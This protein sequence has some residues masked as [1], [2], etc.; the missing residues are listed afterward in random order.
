MKSLD[1]QRKG[2]PPTLHVLWMIP[3]AAALLALAASGPAPA[4]GLQQVPPSD[5]VRIEAVCA[6]GGRLSRVAVNPW[7]LVV[8]TPTE[9]TDR[10][11]EVVWILDNSPGTNVQ[12]ADSIAIQPKDVGEWPFGFTRI[13]SSGRGV[14]R[15]A[16]AKMLNEVP[17]RGGRG[18]PRNVEVGDKFFYNVI[19]FCTVGGSTYTVAIDPDIEGGGA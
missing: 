5:T 1:P 17:A 2:W 15:P 10:N 4:A 19:V 6:G 7:T 3:A 11:T 14:G 12:D 18:Q 13:P 16:R 9:N 8:P